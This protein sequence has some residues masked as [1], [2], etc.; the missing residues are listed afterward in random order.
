MMLVNFFQKYG[1]NLLKNKIKTLFS[2]YAKNENIS[3][4]VT[5]I[6]EIYII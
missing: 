4:F 3:E 6:R 5:K 1:S 2:I